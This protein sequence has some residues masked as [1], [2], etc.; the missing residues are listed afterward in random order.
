[1]GYTSIARGFSICVGC[2]NPIRVC[3]NGRMG[4]DRPSCHLGRILGSKATFHE[5]FPCVLR[6]CVL[7]SHRLRWQATYLLLKDWKRC[8]DRA[9]VNLGRHAGLYFVLHEGTWHHMV[10]N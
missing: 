6:R 3:G 2:E 7:V 10:G 5:E 1:V 9:T 4:R 8:G